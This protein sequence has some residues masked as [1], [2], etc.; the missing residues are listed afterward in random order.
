MI[1][2]YTAYRVFTR[3]LTYVTKSLPVGFVNLRRSRFQKRQHE[4]HC[5]ISGLI[6]RLTVP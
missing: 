3:A 1:L 4:L 2:I 5:H 6:P